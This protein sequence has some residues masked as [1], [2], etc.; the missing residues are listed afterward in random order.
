MFPKSTKTQSK[1]SVLIK[2]RVESFFSKNTLI[3]SDDKSCYND[4]MKQVPK[5]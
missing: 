4:V 5:M 1:W 3:K 2:Y